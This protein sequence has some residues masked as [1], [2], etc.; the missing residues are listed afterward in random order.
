MTGVEPHDA[1]APVADPRLARRFRIVRE[2]GRGT[3]GV[4][5]LAHDAAVGADVALKTFDQPDPA[6]FLRLKDEFRVLRDIVHPNLAR[7]YELVA[8]DPQAYLAMEY[9]DGKSFAAFVGGTSSPAHDGGPARVERLQAAAGGLVRGVRA[10]HEFGRL[11]RDIKPSNVL[12]TASARTVL[13]DFG[14]A[15][16]LRPP[17][18]TAV[19]QNAWSGTLAYLAPEV[20]FGEAV[21]PAADWYS[22]GVLLFEALTGRLPYDRQ[23]LLRMPG[24]GVLPP[25]PADEVDGVP[26]ALDGLVTR[27]LD[28][29]SAARP[30]A[31]EI[32]AVL[33]PPRPDRRAVL[34]SPRRSDTFIGRETEG[35]RLQAAFV[36][37]RSRCTVVE[38]EGPAGI[39]KSELA[40]HVLRRLQESEAAVV[41][42]GRCH[43]QE[44]VG[45]RA[46]DAIVD[47]LSEVLLA[48]HGAGRALPVPPGAADLARL[49]PV[50]R[51]VD[52]YL[53]GADTVEPLAARQRAFTA[54]RTLLTELAER[55]PLV[56]WIDDAHWGDSD[57]EALLRHLLRPPGAPRLLL[58]MSRRSDDARGRDALASLDVERERL[59]LSP[60][61]PE[62]AV[63]LAE[64]LVESLDLAVDPG[65]LATEAHG[66]PFLVT[67]LAH[68]LSESAAVPHEPMSIS[69]L[70]DD[71]LRRLSVEE[72]RFLEVVSLAGRPFD[73]VVALRAAG[74]EPSHLHRIH[75]L[76][77]TKLLRASEA[78]FGP[79]VE[80]YHDRLREHIVA[81]LPADVVRARHLGIVES[82]ELHAA[83]PDELLPHLLAL[84]ERQRALDAA[85]RAA[86]HAERG[87]AFDRAARLLRQVLELEPA[88]DVRAATMSRLAEALANAGFGVAAA[89]AFLE[90][91]AEADRQALGVERTVF[92]RRRAAEHFLRSGH[93]E[94]GVQA[95][96][97]VLASVGIRYPRSDLRAFVEVASQ[98]L[99][100]LPVLRGELRLRPEQADDPALR[101]RLDVCNGAAMSL[102]AVDLLRAE[103]L[104]AR[105]LREAIAFGDASRV[106][107]AL[108]WE[109]IKRIQVGGRR[110][111]ARGEAILATAA[112]LAAGTDNPV[113]QVGLHFA[114]GASHYEAGEWRAAYECCERAAAIVRERCQGMYFERVTIAAFAYSSLAHLGEWQRLRLSLP[115]A[116]AEADARDDLYAGF[117]LRAG[118]MALASL[119]SDRAEEAAAFLDENVTRFP[120]HVFLLQHYLHLIGRVKV[121]LYQGRASLAVERIDRSWPRLRQALYLWMASP[122][123]ELLN[124]QGRALLALAGDAASGRRRLLGRVETAAR[125]LEALPEIASAAPFAALLRAGVRALRGE[126]AQADY[127]AAAH[128]FDRV[129]MCAYAAAARWRAGAVERESARAYFAEQGV[130]DPARFVRVFAPGGMDQ[131]SGQ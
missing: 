123:V 56:L 110:Q 62:D 32:A 57:S 58:L 121:D 61:V 31:A 129:E 9:I 47:R 41:L 82:L 126:P 101:L 113:D 53:P 17:N 76:E 4:V 70:V 45:Y 92:L 81:G 18:T 39:G 88:A 8:D 119:A 60:L 28:P 35:A 25:H 102:G 83:E 42:R 79:T 3:S 24:G 51:G 107:Q 109:A 40:R 59:V 72:R 67:Q 36:R 96:R 55:R 54:L 93:L 6:R 128:A 131:S 118:V 116:I 22:V 44:S 127:V 90:A 120:Q 21:S 69:T 71:R 64:H 30:S 108:E 99:R 19:R 115:A 5:Y 37:S 26:P 100:L 97:A 66:S 11:H 105:H 13:V 38:L 50:L 27:L 14:L 20:L 15:M 80:M 46:F 75:A 49:F 95:T 16:V 74:L 87:L 114:R 33:D 73:R 98:R 125:R 91:A 111:R 103:A 12:V 23:A 48:A 77:A 122:R 68:H 78:Q 29:R 10:L 7:L 117:G 112:Q 65:D 94:E 86:E 1:A 106:A 85:L 84:G 63:R 124:L 43:P 2:L 89:R 130:V 104:G 52:G 34:V